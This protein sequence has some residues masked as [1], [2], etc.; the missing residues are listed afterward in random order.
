MKLLKLS[1]SHLH[2]EEILLRVERQLLCI[3]SF[4]SIKMFVKKCLSSVTEQ[5]FFIQ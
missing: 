4:L 1:R 2:S 5:K 3:L